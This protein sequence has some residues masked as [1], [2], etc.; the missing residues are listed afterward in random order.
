MP[1]D[2]SDTCA[3]QE[4]LLQ[5]GTVQPSRDTRLILQTMD[6]VSGKDEIKEATHRVNRHKKKYCQITILLKYYI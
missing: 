6:L 3:E 1:R 2:P 5:Y 4:T